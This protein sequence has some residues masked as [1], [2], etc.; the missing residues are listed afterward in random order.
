MDNSV[1]DTFK[2]WVKE[3]ENSF[4]YGCHTPLLEFE[5][6]YADFY[7]FLY[8]NRNTVCAASIPEFM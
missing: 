1:G 2:R 5:I 3:I 6:V 7:E 8:R 4:R